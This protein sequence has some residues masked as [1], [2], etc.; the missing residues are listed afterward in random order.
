MVLPL[1]TERLVLRR[2]ESADVEAFAV[3]RS[4]P[5]VAR[6]QSWDVP[7]TV[8][9]A[10]ALI[11][12]QAHMSGPVAGEWIQIA[13]DH[14]GD[15]VGDVAV[16][17]GRDGRTATIGYTL[18]PAFQ[19]RGLAAEMVG[20]IVDALFEAGLHRVEA[21]L[22]PRN[23]ASARVVERLGFR[24]EGTAV[25]SVFDRGEWTD[26]ARYAVLADARRRWRERPLD[27]PADVRLVPITPETHRDVARLVTHETQTRF[28]AT[29][30]ASFGDALFPELVDG[31]PA[32]PWYRLIEADG[33]SAGFVMLAEVT[34]H[35]PE[36]FLWRLLIDRWHQRRGIGT[37][38]LGLLADRL[39][40]EGHTTLL[41]SWSQGVGGPEPFYL[42]HGFVPTG[43]L[44]D[45]HEIEARL[46]L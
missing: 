6:Y 44:V 8:E 20:A 19:G 33:V 15:L 5:A 12:G 1:T 9:M 18:A 30:A 24:F 26:D 27:P 45:G 7:F 29:V 10:T 17:M 3:Y 21:T 38:V 46:P 25:S 13:A 36:A 2:F 28:V 43:R 14:D 41:V 37:R 39:R 42:T 34:E 22:D 4:A 35:H 40:A 16:G 23:I 11:T 31:A 32:V